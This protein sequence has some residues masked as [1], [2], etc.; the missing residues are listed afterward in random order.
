MRFYQLSLIVL[1]SVPHP[2]PAQWGDS[3]IVGGKQVLQAGVNAGSLDTMHAARGMFERV[4]ADTGLS[5]WGHYYIALAD[6][7]IVNYLLGRTDDKKQA[8]C[9]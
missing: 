6:H 1:F 8:S 3:L 9:T 2:V 7:S 4:L 5:A